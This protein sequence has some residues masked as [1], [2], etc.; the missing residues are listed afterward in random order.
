MRA[1]V[2]RNFSP[3]FFITLVVFISV[4]LL[5]F[6][7]S[8]T[9]K[10]LEAQRFQK[11][12]EELEVMFPGMNNYDIEDDLYILYADES[13]IGYGFVATGNGY[14][15][16][17]SILVGLEDAT[18]IKGIIILSN[19]ETPGLGARIVEPVF[20]DQ[21]I[22]LNIDDVNLRDDGGQIDGISSASISS[23]AVVD[24]VRE[25][26]MEKVKLIEQGAN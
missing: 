13:R 25:T 7:E 14:G 12:K 9:S 3:V 16:E 5:S 22:G 20:T 10:E 26:A 4:I 23:E 6:T 15:G 1:S 19:Q 2:L 11:V 18:T 8:F 21:F 24:A 17:I